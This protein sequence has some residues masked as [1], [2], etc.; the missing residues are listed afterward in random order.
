[1]KIL[2]KILKNIFGLE[3]YRKNYENY[4]WVGNGLESSQIKITKYFS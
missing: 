1:M 2:V 3:N 4:F